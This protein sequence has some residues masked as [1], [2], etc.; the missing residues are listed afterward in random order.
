MSSVNRGSKEIRNW[1]TNNI[2]F[3]LYVYTVWVWIKKQRLYYPF[4]FFDPMKEK[5]K[6][7]STSVRPFNNRE[8]REAHT[9]RNEIEILIAIITKYIRMIDACVRSHARGESKPLR[10]KARDP[11]VGVRNGYT[12]GVSPRF[13]SPLRSPSTRSTVHNLRTEPRYVAASRF[14]PRHFSRYS[15]TDLYLYSLSL[16]PDFQTR[17]WKAFR[18]SS[19]LSS[20]LFPL[21]RKPWPGQSV[22]RFFL[23]RWLYHLS[24]ILSSEDSVSREIDGNYYRMF[25]RKKGE[26]CLF[27]KKDTRSRRGWKGRM[28]TVPF[29]ENPVRHVMY[30]GRQT[31]R[32]M[33]PSR[34]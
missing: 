20:S 8:I 24:I 2:I 23:S 11:L 22:R 10:L 29:R 14:S 13:G 32:L 17:S 18:F 4:R 6:Y 5:R 3:N 12:P 19:S 25:S 34:L 16:L 33:R 26:G 1:L 28:R 9:R 30:D 7:E 27:G 31:G 15:I 21:K